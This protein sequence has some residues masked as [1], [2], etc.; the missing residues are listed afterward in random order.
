MKFEALN[1]P[2]SEIIHLIEEWCLNTRN[3]AIMLKRLDGDTYEEIAEEF[4]L[5]TIRVKDIVKTSY[6]RITEHI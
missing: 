3:K 5:S 6:N 4:N 1:L 2:R